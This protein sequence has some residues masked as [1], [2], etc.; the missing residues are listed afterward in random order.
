MFSVTWDQ[1]R[2]SLCTKTLY[3][4]KHYFQ[5]IYK[6]ARTPGSVLQIS[7]IV[8]LD[9]HAQTSFPLLVSHKWI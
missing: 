9:A 1:M 7:I 2:K 4:Q 6:V 3:A 5:L 8:E